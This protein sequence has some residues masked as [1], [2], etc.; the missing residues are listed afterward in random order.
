MTSGTDGSVVNEFVICHR[1]VYN[2]MFNKVD[3]LQFT[4]KKETDVIDFNGN[5]EYVS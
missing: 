5:G 3:R 1:V 4:I 2:Y